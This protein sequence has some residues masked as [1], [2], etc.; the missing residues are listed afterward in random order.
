MAHW[1][2]L[3]LLL[4]GLQLGSSAVPGG[5]TEARL[6]QHFALFASLDSD[7]DGL[8]RFRRQAYP[9]LQ[10]IHK[11]LERAAGRAVACARAAASAGG[12]AVQS[13]AAAAPPECRFC[14]QRLACQLRL[15]RLLINVLDFVDL[16]SRGPLTEPDAAHLRILRWAEWNI[17]KLVHRGDL[18][19]AAAAALDAGRQLGFDWGPYERAYEQLAE[20]FGESWYLDGRERCMDD[21]AVLST[22]VLP[23]EHLRKRPMERPLSHQLY[24]SN[25]HI[26]AVWS[27]SRAVLYDG[28]PEYA[29]PTLSAGNVQ[30]LNTGPDMV[31]LVWALPTAAFEGYLQQQSRAA[32]YKQAAYV[33]SP[34][35]VA[36]GF[37]WNILVMMDGRES[38]LGVQLA[39]IGTDY[40]N[41]HSLLPL[42]DILTGR[43]H[44]AAAMIDKELLIYAAAVLPDH[45]AGRPEKLGPLGLPHRMLG[46]PLM[47]RL[48]GSG[49]DGTAERAG[50][51]FDNASGTLLGILASCMA[52]LLVS[53]VLGPIVYKPLERRRRVAAMQSKLRKE[54][55]R[56]AAAAAA[57]R[58]RAPDAAPAGLG[59]LGGSPAIPEA[60]PLH[61]RVALE[62]IRQEE[63]D[64]AAA[65]SAAAAAAA[66]R[67]ADRQR[68]QRL[69]AEQGTLQRGGS[70]RSSGGEQEAASMAATEHERR[71]RARVVITSAE[72]VIALVAQ[73]EAAAAAAKAQQEERRR[74]AEAAQQEV[75]QRERLAQRQRA[76]LPE[77]PAQLEQAAWEAKP[78]EVLL[79]DLQQQ[80]QKVGRSRAKKGKH[81]NS[82]QHSSPAGVGGA[83]ASP[84]ALQRQPSA[85]STPPSPSPPADYPPTPP[86]PLASDPPPYA[87]GASHAPA[88]PAPP[89]LRQQPAAPPPP[90]QEQAGGEPQSWQP[91]LSPL[92]LPLA[93]YHELR[94]LAGPTPQPSSEPPPRWPPLGA[95]TPA[96]AEGATPGARLPGWQPAAAPALPAAAP[97][98]PGLAAAQHQQQQQALLHQVAGAL[99]GQ[100]AGRTCL[101]CLADAGGDLAELA[102]CGHRALCQS[103]ARVMLAALQAGLHISCPA[104]RAGVDGLRP[105]G[106]APD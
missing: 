25:S 61:E 103:C 36:F 7:T 16:S 37:P 105:A 85:L 13:S 83:A 48:P 54:Q 40:L 104:C 26:A 46:T 35:F 23:R 78:K 44:S 76:A 31:E 73:R 97:A 4:A 15:L 32:E 82:R 89:P 14:R 72:D 81:G 99:H 86:G 93:D 96:S 102:P 24:F 87:A 79:R 55:Q 33:F 20:R 1:C 95:G 45:L 28:I 8:V 39:T 57:A 6:R 27:E 12:N 100:L 98:L 64:K 51:A 66:R 47:R 92:P 70:S 50:R 34:S 53:P 19:A 41:L 90:P 75:A 56:Q 63:E 101:L 5:L 84:G 21:L 60:L 68:Q 2:Y 43:G 49:H 77:Q 3:L 62:L 9:K 42:H 10:S 67:E 69:Q 22:M 71:Q 65:A 29:E 94:G 74:R 58:P 88:A 17:T 59:S 52:V 91:W 30:L 38:H 106:H 11:S 18:A 80:Q